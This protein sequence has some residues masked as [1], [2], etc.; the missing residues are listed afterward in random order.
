MEFLSKVENVY[1]I[2]RRGCVIVPGIPYSFHP[3][4]KIGAK[5]QFRNPSGNKVNTI[6]KGVEIINREKPM[7]HA[8]FL[9]DRNVKKGDIEIGAELYFV[10]NNEK[11]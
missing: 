2:P 5:L 6:L 8:P 11:I 7:D 9:V 3:P 4:L 10:S 1:D